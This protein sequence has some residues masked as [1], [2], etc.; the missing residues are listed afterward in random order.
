MLQPKVQKAKK[1]QHVKDEKLRELSEN[2]E[3]S[4]RYIHEVDGIGKVT[5]VLINI[6]YSV[7]KPTSCS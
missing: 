6:M 4:R 5:W 3:Q 2:R 1:I 7:D